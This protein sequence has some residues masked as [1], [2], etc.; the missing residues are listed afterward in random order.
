M[1]QLLSLELEIS[2]LHF[3][4]GEIIVPGTRETSTAP[5]GFSM[6]FP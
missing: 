5:H 1:L 4:T 6:G 3:L 2:K